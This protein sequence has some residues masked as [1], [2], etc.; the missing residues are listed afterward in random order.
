M[1]KFIK[2]KG[3]SDIYSIS[4]RGDIRNDITGRVLKPWLNKH[5]G[6]MQISLGTPN[7]RY[8]VHS[9]V[10]S[11]FCENKVSVG[12]VSIDHIDMNKENNN[13]DNLEFVS[14]SD[15]IKRSYAHKNGRPSQKGI[16]KPKLAKT[17][18]LTDDERTEIIEALENGAK[19]SDVVKVHS[20][21][22]ATIYRLHNSYKE[23]IGGVSF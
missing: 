5:S 11:Y 2:V 1:L 20:C 10:A 18:F 21:S 8:T 3:H 6:Y 14:Y 13:S 17:V 7:K 16:S 12:K 4:N 23:E 9:L 19:V 15:N 22:S